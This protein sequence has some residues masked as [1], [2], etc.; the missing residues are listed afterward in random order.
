MGDLINSPEVLPNLLASAA[1][2]D[3]CGLQAG[4][5]LHAEQDL[6]P[7]REQLPRS[8]SE[9]SPCSQASAFHAFP[10]LLCKISFSRLLLFRSPDQFPC[11]CK[12]HISLKENVCKT[13]GR[14]GR[15][16]QP[17]WLQSQRLGGSIH[18]SG[19]RNKSFW[20]M[21]ELPSVAAILFYLLR[22]LK[23][24][25]PCLQEIR[26]VDLEEPAGWIYISLRPNDSR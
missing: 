10:T 22:C 1:N 14:R 13:H 26:Q 9:R 11:F 12:F 15:V 20:W 21:L 23:V 19:T 25:A 17:K 5:E 16:E 2:C 8:P 7:V 18:A 24:P 4:R 3:L 6:R